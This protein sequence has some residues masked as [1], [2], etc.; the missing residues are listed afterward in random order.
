MFR[1]SLLV[2]I[3][4]VPVVALAQSPPTQRPGPSLLNPLLERSQINEIREE[5][6]SIVVRGSLVQ[7]DGRRMPGQVIYCDKSRPDGA[8]LAV[9]DLVAQT[10]D[11]IVVDASFCDAFLESARQ[12]QNTQGR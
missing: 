5:S 3:S 8:W 7:P 11:R 1:L 10:D 4:L 12:R 6:G 9:Q 2:A